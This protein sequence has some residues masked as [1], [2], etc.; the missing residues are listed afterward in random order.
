MKKPLDKRG[1]LWYII[2]NMNE[3]Y[4]E[5]LIKE[6]K[7]ETAITLWFKFVG[8]Q[9]LFGALLMGVVGFCLWIAS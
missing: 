5:K 9:L 2:Y 4:T 1:I 8:M 3:L 6:N 7:D